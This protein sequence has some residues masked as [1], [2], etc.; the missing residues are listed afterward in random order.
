M[1]FVLLSLFLL[2]VSLNAYEAANRRPISQTG[3]VNS[4]I[5]LSRTA[6]NRGFYRVC[7]PILAQILYAIQ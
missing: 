2:F 3:D 1:E 4:E 5:A 7:Q 6:E